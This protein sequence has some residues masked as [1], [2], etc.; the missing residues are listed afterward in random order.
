MTWYE[1]IWRVIWRESV[2]KLVLGIAT[3]VLTTIYAFR[4]DAP[5]EEVVAAYQI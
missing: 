5:F 4:R 3:L 2:R 1:S